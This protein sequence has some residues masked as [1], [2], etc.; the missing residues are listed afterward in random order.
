MDL[1][2]IIWPKTAEDAVIVQN[3]L[4]DKIRIENDFDEIKIIAGVDVSYD[5]T[6]NLTRAFIVLLDYQ[7]LQVITSVKAVQPT[8]FPYIPG[9]LSF[10]EI[11]TILEAMKLLPQK[12]EL[13]MVDGQGIAHP[14]RMGIAA[15]LGVLTDMPTIG[16][17][18]SRLTGYY[19]EPG[20]NKGDQSPL[21]YRNEKIGTVLRSKNNVKPLFISPGHRVD[22]D[23]AIEITMHCLTKYRLPEPTRIADKLSKTKEEIPRLL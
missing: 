21:T 17:A 11:P 2:N 15:H 18:K 7:T 1:N 10:R 6:S 20:M 8:T 3:E 14:R 5:I 16:V 9:F 19:T 4:R 12:P 23:T 13:L 22:Q